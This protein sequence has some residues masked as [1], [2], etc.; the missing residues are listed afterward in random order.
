MSRP[1][2][3][4]VVF[5]GKL[6]SRGDFVRNRDGDPITERLDRW[7]TMGVE[8]LA[9]DPRWKEVYDNAPK[10]YFAF[11]GPQSRQ[12]LAGHLTAGTDASGR[13]FPFA[14]V[15]HFDVPSPQAFLHRAPLAL[16]PLWAQLA[17]S[18]E[19]A[20]AAD[21]PVPVLNLAGS[22]ALT[23][24][25][26]SRSYDEPWLRF[27]A[28]QTLGQL[29]DLLQTADAAVDLRQSL[30]GLGFLLQPVPDSGVHELERGV[31][32]PLPQDPRFQIPCAAL[33]LDLIGH[34][35]NRADFEVAL[36]LPRHARW[37]APCAAISFSGDSPAMLHALL[38]PQQINEHFVDLRSPAWAHGLLQ[39]QP[40]AGK[41]AAYLA[42]PGL[43][44]QQA[45]DTFLETFLGVT[46]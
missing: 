37:M 44:L 38:D 42:Q 5:F 15:A 21:D 36:F 30:L 24:D 20:F 39:Q 46:A 23:I 13:R 27:L 45:R 9:Q 26:D 16:G 19:A 41:L 43:A 29:Q 25:V 8:R 31:R 28:G 7:L 40:H 34:F 32:L 33:W 4:D 10:A 6:P 3:A 11:L 22:Q 35:V 12:A 17:R 1:G 2:T 14:M 18:S